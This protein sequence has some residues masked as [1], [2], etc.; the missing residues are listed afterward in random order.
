MEQNYQGWLDSSKTANGS[1]K[2]HKLKS[3]F[4]AKNSLI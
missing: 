1:S 3:L 4:V 2:L